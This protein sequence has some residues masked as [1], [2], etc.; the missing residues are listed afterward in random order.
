MSGVTATNSGDRT[1]S[2]PVSRHGDDGGAWPPVDEA[3]K[4]REIA[5]IPARKRI[6]RLPMGRGDMGLGHGT[7]P[8]FCASKPARLLACLAAS[9][10]GG[11]VKAEGGPPGLQGASATEGWGIAP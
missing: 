8:R 9:S 4:Q 11:R 7:P 6:E 10:G 2:A 5:E 3:G 1:T